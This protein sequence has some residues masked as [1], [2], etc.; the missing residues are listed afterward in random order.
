MD[1]ENEA[2]KIEKMKTGER[3]EGRMKKRTRMKTGNRKK[4]VHE[5]EGQRKHDKEIRKN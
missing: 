5:N 3:K 4:E 2:E 1:D